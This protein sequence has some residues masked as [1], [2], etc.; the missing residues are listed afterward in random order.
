MSVKTMSATMATL[1]LALSGAQ[2]QADTPNYYEC[3]GDNISVSFYD[4]SYGI[5]SSQLN[6]AFGNKKYTADG[7]GIESKATTLG[8]VTSTTIKFMPDVEIK[9]ASFIIPTINLGVNSLGE[10]VSE[11]KF[12]SQLAITTIA[13]PFI[14]G[15]YIGVVN[16][17]KYFDLTCKASLIFI[18]F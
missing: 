6:F 15:P 7:K 1:L 18:H 8:T 17:S 2:A 3:K 12:T 4:K 10:V 11:A 5:G 13:T 9:K 16:S 14:G